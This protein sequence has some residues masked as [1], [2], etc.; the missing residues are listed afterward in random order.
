LHQFQL[1]RQNPRKIP[2]LCLS[3][4][5]NEFGLNKKATTEKQENKFRTVG[6]FSVSG[7]PEEPKGLS[8][9]PEAQLFPA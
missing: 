9:S 4:S 5:T 3:Q 2:Q 8:T 6:P 7:N 1:A